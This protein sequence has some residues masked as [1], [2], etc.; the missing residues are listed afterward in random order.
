MARYKFIDGGVT[1][2]KGFTANGVLCHIKESRTKEDVALI[3]SN[4]ECSAAGIFTQ[5]RVKAECV[6]LDM[7]RIKS[8]RARAVIANSGNANACTGKA[9]AEDAVRMAK[10]AAKA[11]DIAEEDVL[12][13]STGVIGQRLPV[14]KIE[15]S[16]TELAKGLTTEGHTRAAHAIMTTDTKIKECAVEIELFGKTVH[17]GAMCK[18]SGMI[19]LNLGTMLCFITTDADITSR[20]LN[21]AIRYAAE[22]TFNCVSI[23]GDTSTNDTLLI[24]ANGESKAPKI[25]ADGEYYDIF[26]DALTACC[27]VLAKKIASDG[28][29]ATK[30]VE[31]SV[32]GARTE[33]NARG[34]A[35]AVI[36]SN[37][38]KA[39]MFGRDANCGRVLCALGYSGY[40]FDAEHTAVVFS[41]GGK[42][43]TVIENGEGLSFDEDAAREA[44]SSDAV[45]ICVILQEGNAEGF[46]WGCD[47]TYDYVK[48][49]GDYRT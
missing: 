43:V 2:A 26:L 30:L 16:V 48:I 8:G 1:A 3:A 35:K 31:C 15:K 22:R 36:S 4:K 45:E 28:E 5:N 20:M 38:V 29:G 10:C 39:A 24:L 9:G 14:E 32:R 34:L 18:G 19:H 47:L 33:E 6:K 27:T 44:L 11:L 49:N 21:K 41:G 12:V 7:E 17:I 46:A 42:S 37:L 13:C 23:D 25:E 40:E